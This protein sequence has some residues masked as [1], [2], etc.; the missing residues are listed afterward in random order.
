MKTKKYLLEKSSQSIEYVASIKKD[1][2]QEKTFF[3]LK[4]SSADSWTAIAKGENLLQIIDNGNSIRLKYPT[5]Q[6]DIELNYEEFQ[7]LS[8]LIS[9]IK[10]HDKNFFNKYNIITKNKSLS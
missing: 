6:F 9:V 5:K 7:E 4:R 8:L 3:K 1:E 10:S 2:D